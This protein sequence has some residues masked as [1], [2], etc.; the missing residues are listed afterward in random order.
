MP[1]L[2]PA[3]LALLRRPNIARRPP[4]L[5]L[6]IIRKPAELIGDLWRTQSEITQTISRFA[7]KY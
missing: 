1:P 5:L 4:R 6:K 7:Q 2:S 3:R